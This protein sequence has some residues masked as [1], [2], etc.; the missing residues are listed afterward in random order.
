MQSEWCLQTEKLSTI[1]YVVNGAALELQF[2]R[3][4]YVSVIVPA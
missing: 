4:S 2:A 1:F 3:R